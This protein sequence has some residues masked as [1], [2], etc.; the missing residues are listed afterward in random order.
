MTYKAQ[1]EVVGCSDDKTSRGFALK[2]VTLEL[3][4]T[5]GWKTGVR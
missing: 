3:R 1:R 5:Q 4:V 2:R